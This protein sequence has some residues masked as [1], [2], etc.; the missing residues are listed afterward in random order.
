MSRPT[1]LFAGR[2]EQGKV[3]LADPQA[4]RSLLQQHEGRE[5]EL[6]LTRKRKTR[7]TSQNSYYWGCV[8]PFLGDHCG[9]EAEEM[10]AA[11]KMKFLRSHQD[12]ALPSVRSTADLNTAEFTEY[13]E[14]C[15]R[16]G[17]EMGIVI[18]DPGAVE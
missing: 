13:V 4:W 3:Q 17:A 18:P 8:I 15:R 7:S 2:V 14:Q 9:Y 5:I 11:L 10:H 6:R 16:L 1:P 12:G